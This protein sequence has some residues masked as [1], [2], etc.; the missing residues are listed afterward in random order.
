MTA[1]H[2]ARRIVEIEPVLLYFVDCRRP[3]VSRRWRI[4]IV[5]SAVFIVGDDSMLDAH[6][7]ELRRSRRRRDQPFSA[8]T[9]SIGCW[10][11]R[12]RRFLP[13]RLRSSFR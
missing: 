4:V 2:G 1:V 12:F 11:E 9:P 10:E 5:E 13:Q 6:T 3:A 7:G 8:A